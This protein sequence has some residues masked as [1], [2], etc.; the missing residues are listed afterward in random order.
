MVRSKH[1]YPARFDASAD[2]VS[3]DD[4]DAVIVPGGYR[5]DHMRRH[6]R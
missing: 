5:L 6:R 3:A 2:Q 4:F 1:G